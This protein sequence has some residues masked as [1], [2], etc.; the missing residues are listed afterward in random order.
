MHAKFFQF[1]QFFCMSDSATPW[2]VACLCPWD[3]PGKNTSS[4]DSSQPRDLVSL[5][6]LNWQVG[7]L[8]LMLPEK[9]Y[10]FIVCSLTSLS[11]QDLNRVYI[12]K[13]LFGL[14]NLL[15]YYCPSF[16]AILVFP[17][18]TFDLLAKLKQ[19]GRGQGICHFERVT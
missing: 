8:P 19:E 18:P 5:M 10:A 14:L 4:S 11:N 6:S 3:S 17:P 1:F 12:L 9:G 15:F 13:W 16:P 7:S 2:T